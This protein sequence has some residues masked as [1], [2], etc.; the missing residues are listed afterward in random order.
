M[1]SRILLAART[2]SRAFSTVIGC[3]D[4]SECRPAF[5]DKG[6]ASITEMDTSLPEERVILQASAAERREQDV[7]LLS[8]PWGLREIAATEAR[9]FPEIRRELVPR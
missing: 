1:N 4:F 7:E 3:F 2:R 8:D 5:V 6:V 9:P